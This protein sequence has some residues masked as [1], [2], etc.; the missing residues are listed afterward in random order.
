MQTTQRWLLSGRQ[1]DL[2]DGFMVR[3]LLPQVQRRM[4]GPFV[5]FD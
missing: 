5:F 2:G 3:R 1:H 4:V